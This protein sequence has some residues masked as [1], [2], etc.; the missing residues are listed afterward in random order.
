MA[1]VTHIHVR[2][3]GRKMKRMV[4]KSRETCGELRQE[5]EA[6]GVRE[7]GWLSENKETYE[8]LRQDKKCEEFVNQAS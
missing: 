5:Q 4:S 6:R 7:S 2:S 8:M 3:F 1:L